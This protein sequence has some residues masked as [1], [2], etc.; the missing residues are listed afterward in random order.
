MTAKGILQSRRFR[1]FIQSF[2]P[3]WVVMIADVDAPSVLTAADEIHALKF[4]RSRTFFKPEGCSGNLATALHLRRLASLL[5]VLVI[6]LS[7]FN[8]QYSYGE[9]TPFQSLLGFTWPSYRIPVEIQSTQL[10]YPE[11]GVRKAIDIWNLAQEWFL[12]TYQAGAGEAFVLTETMQPSDNQITFTFNRTQT[13]QDLAHGV[14]LESYDKNGYFKRVQAN[15]S[16]DL[17]DRTGAQLPA[18]QLQ[19]LA[20]HE[21]GNA[22][23]LGYV[24]SS[25]SD[26][27][28]HDFLANHATLPSTLNLYA[29]YLLSKAAGNIDKLPEGRVELPPNIP[30]LT[31]PSNVI[32]P[33]LTSS[34]TSPT[35]T[36]PVIITTQSLLPI[37]IA[38]LAAVVILG[39]T[40]FFAIRRRKSPVRT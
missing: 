24:F 18:N 27:M 21:I 32:T 2:G 10:G 4:V 19:A 33:S 14:Y 5:A 17:T 28:S 34:V 37:L 22:L 3:A 31:L 39:L 16:L 12:G 6:A 15:I 13:T 23:G 25:N 1:E 35:N 20:T 7:G 11:Q 8:V 40:A 38:G 30:Y 9:S 29:L 36:G 26:L